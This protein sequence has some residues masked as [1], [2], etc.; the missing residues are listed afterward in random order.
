MF[1]K[2]A[3]TIESK[4]MRRGPTNRRH[5]QLHIIIASI[6]VTSN[7]L[8]AVRCKRKANY[9]TYDKVPLKIYI[10]IYNLHP[11]LQDILQPPSKRRPLY[12]TSAPQTEL[13]LVGV[14]HV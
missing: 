8:A 5:R 9:T 11:A 6:Y 14:K 10:Y 2:L 13:D 7:S 1:N 12:G 4:P 3:Y